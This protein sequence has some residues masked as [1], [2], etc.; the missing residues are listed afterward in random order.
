L[1][2]IWT[3]RQLLKAGAATIAVG[4]TSGG[5]TAPTPDGGLADAKTPDDVAAPPAD[6]GPTTDE[7]SPPDVAQDTPPETPPPP[8]PDLRAPALWHTCVAY[9]RHDATAGVGT[10]FNLFNPASVPMTLDLHLFT[11]DG[12]V[13]VQ[14]HEWKV[15]APEAG[16][17]PTLADLLAE[18]GI[19][20]SF[21]GCLWIGSK[22][23]S[24]PTYMGLQGF[25]ADWYG[26]GNH[27]SSVHGMRDF[28][29]SNHDM[30]WSD[31]V[32]PRVVSTDRFES[33]IAVANGSGVG[34]DLPTD[35]K[36][37]LMV[38]SDAGEE[39]GKIDVGA[40]PPYGCRLVP[41]SQI[42]GSG[43]LIEGTIRLQ[44]PEVGLVA[45]AFVKDKKY[46]GFANADHFFDRNFVDCVPFGS[47]NSC[48]ASLEPF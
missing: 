5:T 48:V 13:A 37:T 20:G 45:L 14:K 43:D 24:G 36:P 18:A 39:L 31:L 26:P 6:D 30:M 4:C 7:A 34:G 15:L 29:N 22:P 33:M 35:A 21:E 27:M 47:V 28:G 44:E 19:E 12:V 3:R 11:P 41:V 8:E 16:A 40:I 46:G 17:H 38:S 42:I 1:K 25:S 32:L 23:E 2:L 10:R 9:V